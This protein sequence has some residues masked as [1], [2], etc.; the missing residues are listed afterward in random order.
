[1]AAEAATGKMAKMAGMVATGVISLFIIH[2]RSLLS[3]P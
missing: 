1:M 3:C 2:R